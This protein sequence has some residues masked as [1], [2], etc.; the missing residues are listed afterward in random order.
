MEMAID[1]AATDRL[2]LYL[3]Y[4]PFMKSG[5]LI[6]C[7]AATWLGKAI[8]AVTGKSVNH[9]SMLLR[10]DEYAGLRNR[11]YLLEAEADGL[12]INILSEWLA[13]YDGSVWWSS[14]HATAEKRD[15]LISWAFD[16]MARGTKYDFKGLLQQLAGRAGLDGRRLFCSE[17]VHKAL[18]E[19]GLIPPPADG[20]VLRPGEFHQL[21][22]FDRPVRIL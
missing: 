8:R 16:E 14:L 18:V 11:R 15:A 1:V 17:F 12:T 21:M 13:G 3:M 9:S 4:Q 2:R 19:T 6:E 20:K 7:R 22:I 5:D 10:L